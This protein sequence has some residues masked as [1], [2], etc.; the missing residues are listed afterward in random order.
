M[1]ANSQ[2]G[3][4]E[5]NIAGSFTTPSS[6]WSNLIGPS[7]AGGLANG[8]QGNQ[9]GV[10]AVGLLP[11]GDYGGPTETIALVAASPAVDAGNTGLAQASGLTVDQRGTGFTRFVNGVVDIGAFEGFKPLDVTTLKDENNDGIEPGLGSGISLREAIQMA[12]SLPTLQRITFA[13]GLTG[14]ITLTLGRLNVTHAISISGPGP[15]LLSVS[16]NNTSQVFGIDDGLPSLSNVT[17]DGLSII[18]GSSGDG[19]GGGIY[20]A[21]NLTLFGVNVSNNTANYNG[22]GI[23]N[24][25]TLTL[26]NSTLSGNS[27]GSLGFGG[28]GILNTGTLTVTNSTLSGNSSVEPGGGILNT[29]T[30]T[31]T[32]STLTGNYAQS[33]GF[34]FGSFDYAGGIQTINGGTTRLYDTIVAGNFRGSGPINASDLDGDTNVQAASSNNLIGAG[35]GGLVNGT[36]GNRVGVNITTVLNTTLAYNGGPTMTHALI[37]GSPA[38]DRGDSRYSVNFLGN[39]LAADQRGFQRVNGAEVDIGAYEAQ[40]A[41]VSPD[42]LANAPWGMPYS[43]TFT[44]TQDGYQPSWGPLTFAVTAGTLPTGL[45]LSSSGVLSGSPMPSQAGKFTF[46]IAASDLAGFGTREF[47]LTINQPPPISLSADLL[48]DGTYRFPYS[49]VFTPTQVGYQPSWGPFTFAVTAGALPAGLSLSTAGVLSGAPDALGS[50]TFLVTASNLSG[51]ASQGYTIT[52]NPAPLPVVDTLSDNLDRDYSAGH[53][54]LREAIEIVQNHAV[55]APVTFAPGLQGTI[56]LSLGALNISTDLDIQGPGA[57]SLTIDAGGHSR[58]F[59][60]SSGDFFNPMNVHISGV[61]ITGGN[62]NDG[63]GIISLGGDLLLSNVVVTGNTGG[64]ISLGFASLTVVDSTISNNTGGGI[65]SDEGL[66]SLVR[67]T[68][69][70][71]SGVAKG[72]GIFLYDGGF[73]TAVNTTISGNS[74]TRG[75]GIYAEGLATPPAE[76]TLTNVTVARNSAVDGAG[77]FTSWATNLTLVN[78]LIADNTGPQ[79]TNDDQGLT[80]ISGPPTPRPSWCRARTWW[81]VGSM[82]S[83]RC[84]RPTRSSGRSKT[85]VGRPR[86]CCSCPAV[87]PSTRATTASYPRT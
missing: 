66:V 23:A 37:P 8:T 19:W 60:I 70:G 82:G 44:A 64:G 49:H 39:P 12:S 67:T 85:T 18:N 24:V 7:G 51:S 69:S 47:T 79:V 65:I 33:L 80:A 22:G 25:G 63:A 50:F 41:S 35:A 76:V 55:D 27:S 56:A 17:I 10:S 5:S 73:L 30:L 4:T 75:G 3:T 81:K 28:G 48:A 11:L 57:D 74:A 86:P 68:V 36:N 62:S 61:T 6:S 87:R 16:G 54:S 32:N 1:A 78:T 71:N 52:I 38:I 43:H 40:Q 20:N 15:N 46:T 58:V 13:P 59:S 21:E 72:G 34:R 29:G 26:T 45:S 2:N 84:C 42:T 14:T 77:V 83:P 31:V 9:V 53:L